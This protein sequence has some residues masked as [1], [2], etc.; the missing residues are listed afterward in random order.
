MRLLN[1]GGIENL[2]CQFLIE[3]S[4][5]DDVVGDQLVYIIKKLL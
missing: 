3:D 2:V 5:V 1:Q 4:D